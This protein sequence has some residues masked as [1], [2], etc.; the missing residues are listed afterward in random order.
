MA[1]EPSHHQKMVLVDYEMPERA[2]G[3]VMG[4]NTLD[5]YWD[6]DDHGYT[7]LSLIHI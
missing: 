3:F 6:R 5:A 2:V 4:H 7:Y 1:G